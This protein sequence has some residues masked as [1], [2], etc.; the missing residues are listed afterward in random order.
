ML[1]FEGFTNAK[2]DQR[3]SFAERI[4]FGEKESIDN[5]LVL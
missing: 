4:D 2:L 5:I 3:P 1:S